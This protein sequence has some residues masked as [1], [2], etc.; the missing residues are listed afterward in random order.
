MDSSSSFDWN[1][2]DQAVNHTR[3]RYE[4]SSSQHLFRKV[5]FDRYKP[6]HSQSPQLWEL[7]T[8][9]DGKEYLFAL[10]DQGEDLT[11]ISAKDWT[12]TPNHDGSSITLAFKQEPIHR[13][14]SK[15]CGFDPAD[16]VEFADFIETKTADPEWVNHL[17]NKAISDERRQSVEQLIRGA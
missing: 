11:T 10:Y 15:D 13:F 1:K 14:A 17:L 4:F 3:T 12:A 5:A 16:A 8:A 2:I 7:R 6:V 9:E